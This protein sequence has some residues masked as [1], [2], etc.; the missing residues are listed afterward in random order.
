MML[1]A[2]GLRRSAAAAARRLSTNKPP[3]P[4]PAMGGGSAAGKAP[5]APTTATPTATSAAAAP[6]TSSSSGPGVGTLLL[7][8]AL[9]APAGAAVYLKQN[10][11]WN[12]EVLRNDANWIKFRELVLGDGAVKKASVPHEK[13]KPAVVKQ[14]KP[15]EPSKTPEE[16]SALISKANPAA[17]LSDK[18]PRAKAAEEPKAAP[19]VEKKVKA[20]SA[21]VAA[22]E[23]K[24]VEQ[25]KV[26]KE[27]SPAKTKKVNEKSEAAKEKT[28]EKEKTRTP[29]AVPEV[30]TIEET[31][32]FVVKVVE[33]A[34]ATER[35]QLD[36]LAEEA[37]PAALGNK[38]EKQIVSTTKEIVETL[39]AEAAEAAF[40]VD[41]NY[42]SG[43]HE[44]DSNALAIRVAQ[45][46][47]EMKHRSKWE[48][49]RLLEALRRMEE[50]AKKKSAEVLHR[51]QALHTELLE[52][53]LR[54][55]HEIITRKTREDLEALKKQYAEDLSRNVQKEKTAILKNLQ[56]KFAADKKAIEDKFASQLKAK[57]ENF[58]E[59]LAKERKQRVQELESYRAELRALN[60]VLERTSTYE[61]FSHQ[62]HKASMA[63]LALSDRIEAAGPL[64]AEIRALREFARNDPFIDSAIKTLPEDVVEKGAASVG[65][66]QERFK[67]VKVVG[68]RAA[69]IP[70]GSGLV[71]QLFGGALSY[72]IIPPGG[73]IEGTSPDAVFSRA[74]Y[75]LKAGD[76]EKAV[77]EL[78]TLTGLP[79]EVSRD[80]IAAAEDRLAVEQTAKV[81]K[82]HISLLAASCS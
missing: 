76:I 69:M 36:K 54:L 52:R 20:D 27:E 9:S 64:R 17:T 45:L 31:K 40:D 25:P 21:N 39:Q 50:D 61:A 70:E 74:D 3:P 6:P 28:E 48:A 56:E 35:R 78:K 5:V 81:I 19:V 47:T 10:P 60:A 44:L 59:T 53:E 22:A 37:T 7:L 57:T 42:L 73:P 33:D 43:I 12:P 71:G 38:I 18:S 58:Q 34:V 41:K 1:R 16:L 32:P 65:Q 14:S 67:T 55:Q 46:A 2:H 72:L 82:A 51:Q 49:V 24:I 63:A 80:W 8:T 23:K 75:A 13:P 15:K 77:S 4:K 26:S 66:L 11:E 68:R 62:V 29:A 79:A 30:S